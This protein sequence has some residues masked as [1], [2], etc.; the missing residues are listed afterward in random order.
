MEAPSR[1]RAGTAAGLQALA[2]AGCDRLRRLPDRPRRRRRDPPSS[3]TAGSTAPSILLGAVLCLARARSVER[4]SER[5]WALHRLNLC[6]WAP[7]RD[8][9]GGDLADDPNAPIPLGRQDALILAPIRFL[10]R[11]RPPGARAG[12][13]ASAALTWLDGAVAALT[14]AAFGAALPPAAEV[15]DA[16]EGPLLADA[17]TLAYPIG[18]TLLLGFLLGV[19]VLVGWR[20]DRELD[21]DRRL[22]GDPA[23]RRRRSTPTRRRPAPTSRAASSTSCSRSRRC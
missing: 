14:V 10:R 12:S 11:D 1:P 6:V 2:I 21:P 3:S 18:D 17:V 23:G 13:G 5:A 20:V 16:L 4:R 9:L 15:I 19:L 8:L 22:A 7:R